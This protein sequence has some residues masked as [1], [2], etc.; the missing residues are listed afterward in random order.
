MKLLYR[1]R[2]AI[3]L[4]GDSG[5]LNFTVQRDAIWS[6]SYIHSALWNGDVV[7]GAAV[8]GGEERV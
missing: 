3:V 6:R 5:I 4:D 8:G 1:F 2:Q 7:A